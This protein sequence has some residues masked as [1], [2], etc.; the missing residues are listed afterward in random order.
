M[1]YKNVTKI[2]IDKRKLEVLIRLGCPDKILI[3]YIKTG[4]LSKTGDFLID[5][6]LECLI[7]F[8]EFNNWGGKRKGAGRPKNQLENQNEIQNI[9][10][11]ED[12]DI[13]KYKDK[14]KKNIYI[15][16]FNEFW[17]EYPKQ[18]AGSKEKAYKSYCKV[19]TDKRATKESLLQAVKNYAQ[20]QEVERGFAKGCAAWLNDDRFN[21]VYKTE[22]SAPM[23]SIDSQQAEEVYQRAERTKQLIEERMK[24]KWGV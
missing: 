7:D 2:I 1:Q 10:Q 12:I 16:D 18:R 9:N 13:D 15:E 17:K 14:S 20:S 11:L 5:D 22:V 24:Q 21:T 6:I 8:K 19:I 3:D 4:N 23:F